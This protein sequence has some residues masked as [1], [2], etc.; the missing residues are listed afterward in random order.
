MIIGVL[1][2]AMATAATART[3][4]QPTVAT[5]D[6]RR[7]LRGCGAVGKQLAQEPNTMWRAGDSA[8][9]DHE[10]LRT[11][12]GED[13]PRTKAMVMIYGAGGHL[14]TSQYSIVVTREV[15]GRWRGTVVGRSKIWVGD[16]PYQ[17]FP[18]KAWTLS[19]Q[20]GRQLDGLLGNKCLFA[21]PVIFE[22]DDSGVSPRD[23]LLIRLEIIT[24]ARRHRASFLSGQV[25]GLTARVVDLSFP[26]YND[27]PPGRNADR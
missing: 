10:S 11:A 16:A 21:E 17:P 27:S 22:G 4:D 18:R 26:K 24:P 3:E 13:L 2:I 6:A 14:A 12:L 8:L 7:I 5:V 23:A 20:D 1:S 19:V 15:D 9:A 25:K